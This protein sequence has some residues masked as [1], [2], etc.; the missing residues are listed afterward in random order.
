MQLS[1]T[2]LALAALGLQ[3]TLAQPAHKRHQH[4]HK[5]GNGDVAGVYARDVDFSN[6]DLYKDV[7]WS[8]VFSAAAATPSA[9][10][11]EIYTPALSTPTPA[12]PADVPNYPKEDRK[13]KDEQKEKQESQ[14][15]EE[16]PADKPES[17][18]APT[19]HSSPKGFGDRSDPVDDGNQDHYIGNV[20][21][22]YGSNMIFI[23]ESEKGGYKYTMTITNIEDAETNYIVWNK[24][25]K[26]GRPQS[27]MGSEPN[28]KFTLGAR[29]SQM[30]AFDENSQVAFSRDCERNKLGG[31]LP[32]CTWGEA[33]FGDLRNGGWS[34]Y[35]CSSIQNS[36][37]NVGHCKISCDGAKTSSNLENSFTHVSQTNAGG[38]LAPGP[39]A[40]YAE[41]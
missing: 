24:S 26:D 41:I 9:S 30:I 10:P 19:D 17:H 16:K 28:L 2:A 11:V 12:A 36:K 3:C 21:R 33:D 40:F 35:D 6:K 32:D 7:D 31:N 34:G 37:G 18:T 13:P 23:D 15:E 27:G 14:K 8:S 25:G 5:R 22:P 38:A 29:K 4:R 39:V 1:Y 20:G